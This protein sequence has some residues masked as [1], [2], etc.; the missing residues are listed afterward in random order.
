MPIYDFNAPGPANLEDMRF[1]PKAYPG[2]D[3]RNPSITPKPVAIDTPNE[4]RE[5]IEFDKTSIQYPD[6]VREI[7]AKGFYTMDRGIKNYFAGVRVPTKDNYKMVQVRIAG[8][9]KYDL[10]WRQDILNGRVQLPVMSIDRT[11]ANYFPEKFSPPHH[12]MDRRY[13]PN[14]NK[15]TLVYRPVPYLIDYSLSLWAESKTDAENAMYQI[16]TRFHPLAEFVVEDEYLKGAV[17]LRF[18]GFS[19]ASDKEAPADDHPK[20]RYEISVT[21]EGW[22]PLPEKTLPTILGTVHNFKEITGDVLFNQIGTDETI[23]S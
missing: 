18:N 23:T 1:T 3:E 14:A 16:M 12:Y 6:E 8:G 20:V 17:Q 7:L 22:L 2:G 11:G 4:K 5:I 10:V 9:R 15:V 13:S 21:M 19:D